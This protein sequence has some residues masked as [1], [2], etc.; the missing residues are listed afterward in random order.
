MASP[1]TQRGNVAHMYGTKGRYEP[2]VS[3]VWAAR[4]R[5]DG[6]GWQDLGYFS[7][8]GSVDYAVREMIAVLVRRR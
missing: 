7:T 3:V 6:G 8:T 1:R 5:V 2:T 4:W